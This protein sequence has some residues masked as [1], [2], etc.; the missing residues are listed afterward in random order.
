MCKGETAWNY[1]TEP[2]DSFF[3]GTQR[4]QPL[5]DNR[6]IELDPCGLSVTPLGKCSLRNICMS[7]DARLWAHQPNAQLF[8]L[9]I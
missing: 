7:L 4:L 5:V 1:Y 3:D 6:L 9:S 8:S 2:C